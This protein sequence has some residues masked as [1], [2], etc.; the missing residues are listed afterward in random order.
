MEVACTNVQFRG[1]TE[2]FCTSLSNICTSLALR[3]FSDEFHSLIGRNRAKI[4]TTYHTQMLQTLRCSALPTELISQLVVGLTGR[5]LY[6][7][8]GPLSQMSLVRLPHKPNFLSPTLF[9]H[10]D[11]RGPSLVVT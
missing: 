11:V 4:T 8:T 7:F 2:T 9:W 10:C 3:K 1:K 5:L 6:S